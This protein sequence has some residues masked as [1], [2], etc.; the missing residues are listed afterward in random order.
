MSHAGSRAGTISITKYTGDRAQRTRLDRIL[1][2]TGESRG[3]NGG[4]QGAAGLVKADIGDSGGIAA[5]LS[6]RHMRSPV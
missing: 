4:D 6:N 3:P 2:L 5:A 1:A